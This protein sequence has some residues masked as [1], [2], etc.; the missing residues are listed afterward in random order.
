[1]DARSSTP[2]ELNALMQRDYKRWADVIKKNNI[3]AD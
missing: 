3:R 1:M 2:Q